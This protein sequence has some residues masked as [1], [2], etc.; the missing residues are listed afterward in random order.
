MW[1]IEKD[2]TL[3][4]GTTTQALVAQFYVR[5]QSDDIDGSGSLLSG[6]SV[7]FNI[8]QWATAIEGGLTN[9]SFRPALAQ[10]LLLTGF[11]SHALPASSRRSPED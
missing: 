1:L 8:S 4:D 6:D 5:V 9:D 11:R 3:P 7:N 2:I 10:T